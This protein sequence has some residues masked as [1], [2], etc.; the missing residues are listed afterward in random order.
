MDGEDKISMEEE[1]EDDANSESDLSDEEGEEE[2]EGGEEEDG[3]EEEE[4]EATPYVKAPKEEF[5]E[6][7]DKAQTEEFAEENKSVIWELLKQVR[8]MK[9]SANYFSRL[10]FRGVSA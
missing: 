5:G 4:E 1:E 3:E 10:L 6:L 9:Q 8:D 2:E 7:G